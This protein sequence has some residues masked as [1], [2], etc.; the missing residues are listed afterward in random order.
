MNSPTQSH[1]AKACI[2]VLALLALF[3]A[4]C[5]LPQGYR[6]DHAVVAK[7]TK[8]DVRHTL[9]EDLQPWMS[10]SSALRLGD[11]AYSTVSRT[12]AFDAAMS[13]LTIPRPGVNDCD[14]FAWMAKSKIIEEQRELKFDGLPAAFGVLWTTNHAFNI[15]LNPEG[16]VELMDPQTGFCSTPKDMLQPCVGLVDLVVF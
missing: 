6:Q 10:G 16:K 15:Y 3:C 5:S 7:M 8:M 11:G 9:A 1:A 4:S 12:E 14:D 2:S 13:S